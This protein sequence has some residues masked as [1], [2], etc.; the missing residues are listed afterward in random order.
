MQ[1]NDIEKNVKNSW[2][3]V[4]TI[5]GLTIASYVGWFFI[6]NDFS[7][8]KDPGNWGAFGDFIGGLLNPLI[9]F[10]AFYWLT[11]S[12][13]VQKQ[14]LAETRKALSDASQAQVEQAELAR[15]NAEVEV[16]NMRFQL[17]LSELNAE[18]EY[19]NQIVSN[20]NNPGRVQIIDDD[21]NNLPIK[22]NA[23]GCH[24]KIQQLEVD[25][26][27]LIKTADKLTART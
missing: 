19:L 24:K 20:P 13:L 17:L 14:E 4:V 10:S 6:V 1:F 15:K 18:R 3:T 12:V 23:P 7:L 25:L 22:E 8:S 16:V 5:F 27:E 2:W 26:T 9:A 21:G 11:I